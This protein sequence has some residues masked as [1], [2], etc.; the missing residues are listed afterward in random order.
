MKQLAN[1]DQLRVESSSRPKETSS[2]PVKITVQAAMPAAL[3][4]LR[5]YDENIE[6]SE[7]QPRTVEHEEFPEE[8][9]LHEEE[10]VEGVQQEPQGTYTDN[11]IKA[12]KQ[13]ISVEVDVHK[14]K[15]LYWELKVVETTKSKFKDVDSLY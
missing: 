2:A 7:G 6:E 1:K 4:M 10:Q 3:E 14:I 5:E 11:L 9:F 15:E 12:L 13:K 8:G